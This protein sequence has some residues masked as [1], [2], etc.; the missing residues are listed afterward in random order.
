MVPLPPAETLSAEVTVQ[1]QRLEEGELI[2]V[3]EA[4][5]RAGID[6]QDID[7]A[8]EAERVADLVGGGADEVV[9]PRPVMPSARIEVPGEI[10]GEADRTRPTASRW[11]ARGRAISRLPG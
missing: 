1:V 7:A 9:G 11:R 8:G 10:A 4:G 3:E 5:G 2:V 6:V